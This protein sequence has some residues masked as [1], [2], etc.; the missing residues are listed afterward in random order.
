MAQSGYAEDETARVMAL[1]DDQAAETIQGEI[2][3][4]R[5]AEIVQTGATMVNAVDLAPDA[6]SSADGSPVQ[7]SV[8]LDVSEVSYKKGGGEA[9][10]NIENPLVKTKLS[11]SKMDGCLIVSHMEVL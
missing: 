6:A 3:F 10:T 9:V 7:V 2:D 4:F 8:E 5:V 1:S 11:L